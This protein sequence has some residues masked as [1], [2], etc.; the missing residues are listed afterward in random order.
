MARLIEIHEIEEFSE[1]R[2]I[3]NGAIDKGILSN[4]RDLDEE[5][6]MEPFLLQILYD[7]NRTPHGPTEIADILTTHVHVGGDKRL[8]AFV[9]KGKSFKKVSSRD[10][11]HQFAKLRQIPELSLMVFAAIGN[12][13][14]DAQR[15]FV[16]T[17][18]DAGCDYLIID[19]Q[20]LSRLFVA[21][22][23]ICPKDGT[24]YSET[25]TCKNGHELDQGISLEM[26]VRE[27]IKYSIERQKD[28]SHIGAKRYS[29]I[30]LLDKHYSK[31]VIRTII[32][33]VSEELKHSNYYR[34]E[35][36]K[37]HWGENTGTG[38]LAVHS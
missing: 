6:E 34:S 10:V 3:P 5:K 28:L 30:V 19:C 2:S 32:H 8:A 7:P 31:E 4:V 25:G 11:T 23:K 20:D 16:Q 37:V 15:D 13:Q 24:P 18:E 9:L 35:R 29:A 12:I 38:G 1:A 27:K 14:D 21:Y 26:E 36:V 22:D 33:E 17:A